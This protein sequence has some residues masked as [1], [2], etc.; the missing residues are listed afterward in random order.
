MNDSKCI[1][2]GM[3]IRSPDEAAPGATEKPH[4]HH[5]S[6]DDGTMKSYEDVLFGMTRFIVNAQGLDEVVARQMATE[7]MGKLPA[8]VGRRQ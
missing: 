4:C 2:C 1:S 5:C 7:M 8:W 3:P 6:N